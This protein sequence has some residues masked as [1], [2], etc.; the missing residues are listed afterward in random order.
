MNVS[1]LPTT[2]AAVVLVLAV[3][4]LAGQAP[5]KSVKLL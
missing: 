5:V 1:H 4:P 2:L 3:A